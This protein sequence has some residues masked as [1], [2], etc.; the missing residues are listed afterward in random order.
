MTKHVNGS[1]SSGGK[2]YLTSSTVTEILKHAAGG[3]NVT[4]NRSSEGGGGK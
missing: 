4:C 1:N 3:G 2:G